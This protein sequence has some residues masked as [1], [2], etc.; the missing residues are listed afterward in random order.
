MKA[1]TRE[2]AIRWIIGLCS[3]V[4]FG[5]LLRTVDLAKTLHL[6]ASRGPLLALGLLPYFFQISLDSRAWRTLLAGLGRRVSWFRLI[7]IRL[8]TEA[9]LMSVPVGGLLSETLKP[10]LLAKTDRVPAAETVASIGV[11]K[12]LLVFA[13]AAYLTIALVVGYDLFVLH[14]EAIVDSAGLPWLVLAAIV[15][16]GFTGLGLGVLFT[17]GA[18]SGRTHRLLIKL[19]FPR[20][21]HWLEERHAKFAYADSCFVALGKQRGHMV[22]AWG[23]LLGAWFIESFETWLLLHLIGFEISYTDAFAMEAAVVFLRN[24]AFF[25]PAGLGVQD[26]GYLA[27]LHAFGVPDVGSAAFVILKRAKELVW[28]ALGYLVLLVLEGKRYAVPSAASVP[29]NIGAQLS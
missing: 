21:R 9:V 22:R 6:L 2:R 24:M 1:S 11:K 28:I 13:E 5:F 16:L 8:S 4:A 18:V 3:V 15:F 10:Y 17:M 29:T 27:F 7:C 26:A 23:F 14:S 20:I 25:M 12:C 19:P